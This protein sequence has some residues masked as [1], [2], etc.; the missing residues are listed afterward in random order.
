MSLGQKRISQ[1]SDDGTLRATIEFG[2]GE[3]TI[4][5]HGFAQTRRRCK[6]QRVAP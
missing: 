4:T 2:S 6:P 3:Q 1:L 5:L